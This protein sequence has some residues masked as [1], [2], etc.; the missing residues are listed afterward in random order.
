MIITH[1][2][3]GDV[4]IAQV[5]TV[6]EA[7]G[8]SGTVNNNDGDIYFYSEIT[9]DTGLSLQK[10][11]N[12]ESAKRINP[13]DMEKPIVI[14][15]NSPGGDALAALNLYDQISSLVERGY[16]IYIIVEGEV[17]SGATLLLCAANKVYMY[18]NSF[19]MVHQLSTFLGGTYQDILDNKELL[20]NIMARVKNVYRSG[21]GLMDNEI[22]EMLERNTFMDSTT[23]LQK[24]FIDTII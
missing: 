2:F 8:D 3:D 20:D 15:L 12:K 5:E 4:E 17:A 14:H 10:K 13:W 16:K 1:S 6:G 19:I 22:D 9:A 7:V 11:I 18:Q 21:T 24:G 23:A